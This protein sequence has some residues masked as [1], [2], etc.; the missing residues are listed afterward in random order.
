MRTPGINIGAKSGSAQN[1][2]SKETHAWVAGYFPVEDPEVVFV[3]LLE[4]AGGGGKVA[5][6]V[7][8]QFVDKYL[9]LKNSGKFIVD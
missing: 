5:G 4:G 3:V 9:E 7:A 2:Q 8:K 6:G 1:A